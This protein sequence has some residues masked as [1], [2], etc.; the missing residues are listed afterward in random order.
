VA[1][2]GMEMSAVE[3]TA[4]AGMDGW[5][6]RP[7]VWT[8]AYAVLIFA[9]WWVMM[10]AMMLPSAAPM[11]LLFARVN[12]KDKS[13]G[14]PL[15]PIALFAAGYLLVWGGFCVVATAL[16]WGLESARLLSPMLVTTNHWLGARTIT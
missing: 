14:A 8:P 15:V 7:A 3:M 1:G 12:R 4:M 16:Q 5:L 9:M 6:M 10:V 11:L 13:A 2:A